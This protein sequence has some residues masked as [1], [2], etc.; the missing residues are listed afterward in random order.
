M[1][2]VLMHVGTP[3]EGMTP[4]SGRYPY[5]SGEHGHQRDT[6]FLWRVEE[7]KRKGITDEKDLVKALGLKSTTEYRDL[8]TNARAADR[9]AKVAKASQ[10]YN[11]GMGYSDIAVAMGMNKS[12]EST[13]RSWLNP[14]IKE[15]AEIGANT[16]KMLKENVDKKKYIDV[17]VGVEN[18]LG[19]SQNK[20]RAAVKSLESEGYHVET[21]YV[22]QLGTGKQTTLKVLC[23]PE[24]TWA[25]VSKNR[26]KIALCT[27]YTENG[28][29]SYLNLEKPVSVD[30]KRIQINYESPKDGVIELRR[31]VPDISLG[32]ADYA[33][34]RIA[35][36][37]THYLKGM[38][39]YSDK[40][41]PGID[42]MF[43]TNKSPDVPMKGDKDNEVLKRLKTDKDNPF[44]ATIKPE[45]KLQL[46]QRHYIDENGKRRLSAINIVNEEGDWANWSKSLSSQFLSKQSS[47]MAKKQLDLAYANQNDEF[48]TIKNLTNPIIK[49]KLLDQFADDCDSKAVHL[50]AAGLPR[51]ASH[52]ILPFPN[53][54]STEVYAP[55]YR[56]G[57]R[58][59]LIRYPHGGKFE[60]PEL[61]VNNNNREAKR[62]LG[63]SPDAI[64]INQE[65][66]HRLSG[67]DFDGDTVLVIP[68]NRKV[69]VDTINPDKSKY[70]KDL[71]NF[72]PQS[73]YPKYEGM[74]VMTSRQKGI[75][76]GRVTNLIT[77]MQLQNAS[78]EEIC[79]AVKHSMVV[80]DAEKH[81]LNWQQSEK[82]FGIRQLM[83]KYQGSSMG[84][85]STLISRASSEQ[86]VPARKEKRPSQ[87]TP[88][89]L[90]RYYEGEK[91]WEP[92]GKT[93]I[94]KKTGEV[95]G[96]VIKSTKAY[97]IDDAFKLTSG[98]SKQNPGT[99]IE[100]VYATHSNKMKALGNAARK[101]SR[102]IEMPGVNSSAK[103]VYAAEVASLNAKWN[104]GM[105]NKPLERQAQ[106]IANKTVAAKRASNP[107]MDADDVK[108]LRAQA[109]DAARH[110]VGKP[111]YVLTIN[112]REWE[113]IQAG[114]VSS[115]KL[116]QIIDFADAD[117][118]KQR[119]MPRETRGL[120]AS[121]QSRIKAM[122]AAGY[123]QREIADKLGVSLSTVSNV[124]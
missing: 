110:R 77:D 85:A 97:E 117:A 79:R 5:G 121:Q 88:E 90:K 11:Q 83:K 26:D 21:L 17:G 78:E 16:A 30:S 15:R 64:G 70:F 35:V 100:S 67:A 82:D 123:T 99:V 119:A 109:L 48:S 112:D 84:G 81:E 9:A 65:V 80:I 89:E 44:G 55:N 86:R 101:E 103:K 92:T 94:D 43:N 98:G 69:R 33:Q 40:M 68:V 113:A 106:L 12:Q 39:M 45:E 13:V 20:L 120:T 31:G 71:Q 52:V 1:K 49:Q 116:K 73:A 51:Q 87:M 66:A 118:V 14:E 6:S 122:Y 115:T 91:I 96:N 59:V 18:W 75:E 3:H 42:I 29:R 107:D 62:V 114:A 27:N 57:E 36:D 23:G 102:G 41:P 7:Y 32:N 4:H 105:K 19:I 61:V 124:L 25:D 53:M 108:R 111:P 95:K 46:G 58:V 22:E 104:E 56:D 76:M 72:D 93:H 47:V 37:G 34:V 24:T 8:L 50:K 28:G 38:A 74:K 54:K 10:L 60:I 63:K 2:D